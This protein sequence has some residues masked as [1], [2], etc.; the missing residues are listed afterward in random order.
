MGIPLSELE[1]KIS[2]KEENTYR[3]VIQIKELCSFSGSKEHQFTTLDHNNMTAD[4]NVHSSAHV[5]FIYNK[6]SVHDRKRCVCSSV[7]CSKWCL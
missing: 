2:V 7:V 5:S 6:Y 4:L 1:D 3:P